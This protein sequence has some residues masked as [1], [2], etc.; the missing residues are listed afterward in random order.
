MNDRIATIM[1]L[2]EQL[3]E[4]EKTL[5]TNTLSNHFEKQLQLSV[6]ELSTC[7]ED[8]LIIIRNVINGVILTKNHVP[9]IVEAYERLKD[10]DVPRK[11]SLGRTEE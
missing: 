6:A 10:T 1:S 5:I 4:E 11:I 8:E 2:C 7:N 9:N 3:N